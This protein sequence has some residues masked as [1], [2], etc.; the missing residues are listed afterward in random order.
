MRGNAEGQTQTI[1]ELL[2]ILKDK[3]NNNPP[4]L[5]MEEMKKQ[6]DR[7]ISDSISKS[8]LSGI[9]LVLLSFHLITKYADT[10]YYQIS[11]LGIKLLDVMK[12]NIKLHDVIAKALK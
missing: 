1:Q 11:N 3:L 8:R 9:I 12:K 6:L 2:K 10:N 5:K 4:G 7:K